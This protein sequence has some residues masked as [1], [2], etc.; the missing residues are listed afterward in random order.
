[1]RVLGSSFIRGGRRR[2]RERRALSYLVL[3]GNPVSR[4]LAAA[5]AVCVGKTKYSRHAS[6]VLSP[7]CDDCDYNLELGIA[8]EYGQMR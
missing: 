2:G 5:A 8:Q 6:L 1:V 3:D 7:S 4:D